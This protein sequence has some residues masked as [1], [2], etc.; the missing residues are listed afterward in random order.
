[1]QPTQTTTD[2]IG[3]GCRCW[4]WPCRCWWPPAE[5]G[6]AE[7]CIQKGV[8]ICM[9]MLY[10]LAVRFLAG[11]ASHRFSVPRAGLRADR[12]R[13]AGRTCLQAVQSRR[14][15]TDGPNAGESIWGFIITPLLKPIVSSRT[16]A[17]SSSSVIAAQSSLSVIC[18]QL[19]R[20]PWSDLPAHY[21]S[22]WQRG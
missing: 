5:I 1:M 18:L 15:A 17:G 2:S 8:D 13:S 9:S 22:L 4:W 12:K 14:P 16:K 7:M 21:G 10:K 20:I 3:Y 11:Y 19:D 6:Y